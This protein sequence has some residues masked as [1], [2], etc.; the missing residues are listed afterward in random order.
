MISNPATEAYRPI[1]LIENNAFAFC[2]MILSFLHRTDRANLGT[3]AA[4]Q[5][6]RLIDHQ[7]YVVRVNALLRTY[8]YAGLAPYAGVRDDV[9]FWFLFRTAEAE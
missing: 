6:V 5:A 8:C 7:L 9:P 4:M 2:V 3:A 1:S